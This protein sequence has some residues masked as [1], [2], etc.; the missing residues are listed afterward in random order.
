[1]SWGCVRVFLA[2]PGPFHQGPHDDVGYNRTWNGEKERPYQGRP[3]QAYKYVAVQIIPYRDVP[4]F[5]VAR[6]GSMQHAVSDLV[7]PPENRGH[8]GKDYIMQSDRDRGREFIGFAQPGDADRQQCF[9][10]P[11][12]RKAEEN[13]DGRTECDRMR[14]VRDGHQG[15]VVRTK[16]ALKAHERTREPG[17]ISQSCFVHKET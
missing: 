9:H 13:A 5:N 2:T 3:N 16:P 10:A 11:E 4:D 7:F 12:R 17:A 1:M 6:S 15:H 14:S 8:Q